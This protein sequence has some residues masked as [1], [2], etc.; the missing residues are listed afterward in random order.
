MVMVSCL[1]VWGQYR[2]DR[3]MF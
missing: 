1:V 2:A 3:L